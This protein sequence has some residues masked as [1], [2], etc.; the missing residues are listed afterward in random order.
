M[1]T[2]EDKIK[3]SVI[4]LDWITTQLNN[5]KTVQITS[6]LKSIV[7]NKKHINLF[8]VTKN[9]LYIQMGKRFECIDYCKITAH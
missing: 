3:D 2:Q 9:G 7:C 4:K 6:Y 1:K 5:D 8:K